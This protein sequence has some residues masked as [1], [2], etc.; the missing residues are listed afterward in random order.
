VV[1]GLPGFLLKLLLGCFYAVAGV[2]K[3]AARGLLLLGCSGWSKVVMLLLCIYQG[4]LGGSQ[5]DVMSSLG[6]FE[7]L[8]RCC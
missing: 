4:D 7:W 5:V 3:V 2:L 8:P 1:L 6:C